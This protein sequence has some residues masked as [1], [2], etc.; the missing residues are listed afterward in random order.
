MIKKNFYIFLMCLL[1]CSSSEDEPQKNMAFISGGQVFFGA[2]DGRENESPVVNLYVKPFY[3]D[4]KEVSNSDFQKFVD[5]TSHI[6]SAE[7]IGSSMLY[8]KKWEIIPNISWKNRPYGHKN[9][10]EDFDS[11]PVVHVSW[12][13]ANAYC[14]WKKK[15]L[16]TEHEFEFVLENNPT[17]NSNIWQGTFPD[18]NSIEDGYYWTSPVGSFE[19]NSLGIY[20]LAG[21]VWEWTSDNYNF[22]V[23]DILTINGGDT[24]EAWL[25]ASY[26]PSMENQHATQKVL[27][28]GSFLCHDSYCC[29]YKAEA[30]MSAEPSSSYFHV[31]FRCACDL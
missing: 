30:R 11:L 16:P 22:N 9:N 7:E 4:K 18:N 29:G 31:G 23:H 8:T 28:G 1:G 3:L 10:L 25:K 15:R 13:D 17:K 12:Y 6:T 26:D 21:N 2:E 20:D 5:A 14:K 24:S 27:K 19:A